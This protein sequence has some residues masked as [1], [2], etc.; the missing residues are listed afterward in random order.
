MRENATRDVEGGNLRAPG[1]LA[2]RKF[3][4]SDS[5]RLG[6]VLRERQRRQQQRQR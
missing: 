4:S 6:R 2:R 5:D 3:A 1:R